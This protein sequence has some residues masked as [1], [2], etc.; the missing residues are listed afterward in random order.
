MSIDT[1]AWVKDAVFYQV[2]PDRFARSGRVHAPGPLEAWDT[3]PT[4][5][6]FKGGDLYGVIDH[7]DHLEALG[8]TAIYLNPV[9]ASASNHR[10]HT[11][12]YLA[13][14]PLLGGDAALRELLDRA[15]AR[16]MR[17]VLDGVFNH[18]SRGFWA[19]H[20]VLECGLGSPYLDWFYVN[21]EYLRSGRTLDAYP[22]RALPT[23]DHA[24]SPWLTRTGEW[25]Y[26]E[27]GYKAWWDLP[28]LP[29]LNVDNPEV[30]EYLMGVAEHWIRFG[31]DGWRLDV[32]DEIEDDDF[33]REFRRR[34]KTLNPE[35]YIVAEIWSLEPGVL[36][37]DMYDSLMNYPLGAA[38]VSFAGAGRIDRAVADTHAGVGAFVHDDDGPTFGRRLTEVISAYP[39]EV[40]A[41][42][43]NLLDSH[44]TPRILSIC[45]GDTASVKIAMLAQMML[46][47]APCIYYGD[48]IGMT[49]AFDPD[50]RRTFPWDRPEAWDRD[51]LAYV[52]AAVALRHARPALR[53]GAF[54]IAGAAGPVVAW[55]RTSD[56][57]DA[58]LVALNNGEAPEAI[59][60]DVPELA[61]RT[62]HPALLPGNEPGDPLGV[63]AGS[64]VINIP[65]RSGRVFTS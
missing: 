45:S 26:R 50:C 1:P 8:V 14:D 28:A 63:P 7:L 61:G 3:P 10:Y 6:G 21:H 37:G 35:A 62:L 32:P 44:D 52:S 19:F 13:V 12:D 55:A 49:G 29:K 31:I 47:G 58:A 64:F 38:A 53:Q 34:V 22:T 36:Q 16:G 27:L 2:F 51:L 56:D 48:E 17:V 33:W 46:P 60:I 39:P 15:H 5:H 4:H 41:V 54:R 25:S 18:A 24:D 9:F 65:A 43:L 30:R 20:H 42:Q 23:L 57:G 11:Y 40:A 59:A